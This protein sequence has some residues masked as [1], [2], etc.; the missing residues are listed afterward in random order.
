[1]SRSAL[2]IVMLMGFV[3]ETMAGGTFDGR[4]HG[5]PWGVGSDD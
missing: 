1:M 4:F 2:S 3:A 5:P